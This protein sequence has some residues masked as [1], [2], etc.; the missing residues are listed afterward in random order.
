MKIGILTF[1]NSPSFG[2]SLQMRGLYRALQDLG[3][4][5][6]IINYQNTFMAKNKHIGKKNTVKNI[7]LFFLDISSKKKF[8]KFEKQLQFFPNKTLV[9]DA[10]LILRSLFLHSKLPLMNIC[11]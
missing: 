4:E 11:S 10:V 1:P 2:A 5:V 6:E 7:I 9:Q 8:S 3:S